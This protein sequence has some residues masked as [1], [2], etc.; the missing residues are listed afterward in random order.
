M[1]EREDEEQEEEVG[2]ASGTD[3]SGYPISLID[4]QARAQ[5]RVEHLYVRPKVWHC[6][7]CGWRCD[8]P[9]DDYQ[10]RN[11]EAVRPFTGGSATMVQ[12]LRCAEWSLGV[13]MFCEWCGGL[14]GSLHPE[15]SL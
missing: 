15:E 11:C 10:C 13:A 9:A 12:C 7:Y 8:D 14:M 2:P 4:R 5:G 6:I 3:D 1:P